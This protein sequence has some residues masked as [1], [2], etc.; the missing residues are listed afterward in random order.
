MELHFTPQANTKKGTTP[1]FFLPAGSFVT[2]FAAKMGGVE[3]PRADR[4]LA[5]LIHKK[6]LI[7]EPLLFLLLFVYLFFE[8]FRLL[9][10]AKKKL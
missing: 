4:I 8:V 6:R 10:G 5:Y 3:V 2:R 7:F 9:V 1:L